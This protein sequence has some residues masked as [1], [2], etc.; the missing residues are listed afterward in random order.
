MKHKSRLHESDDYPKEDEK[1]PLDQVTVFN[2]ETI[3]GKILIELMASVVNKKLYDYFQG[4]SKEGAVLRIYFSTDALKEQLIDFIDHFESMA[5]GDESDKVMGPGQLSLQKGEQDKEVWCLEF[6][7]YLPDDED[8]DPKDLEHQHYPIGVEVA[9]DMAVTKNGEK[10]DDVMKQECDFQCGKCGKRALIEDVLTEAATLTCPV[11]K[12]KYSFSA[13]LTEPGVAPEGGADLSKKEPGEG[14]EEPGAEEQSPASETPEG[15]EGASG[16]ETAS[17]GGG[18]EVP[19]IGAKESVAKGYD[20][21]M[22]ALEEGKV[23]VKSLLSEKE[24]DDADEWEGDFSAFI[25]KLFGVFNELGIVADE[26]QQV[27][28]QQMVDDG[29]IEVKTDK[30]KIDV[31]KFKGALVDHMNEQMAEVMTG[32]APA[33]PSEPAPESST[34]AEEPPM[35]EAAPLGGDVPVGESKDEKDEEKDA[36]ERVRLIVK[37]FFE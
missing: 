21:L 35:P 11:C 3:L 32:E 31:K 16:A 1:D 24:S 2:P 5:L 23:T 36:E 12:S 30:I 13:Y 37:K 6:A 25:G 26:S 28:I 8:E 9:G 17:G 7:L 22:R 33:V 18:G 19:Q 10:G 4:Y 29:S 15:A 27:F 20:A 14:G 34:P